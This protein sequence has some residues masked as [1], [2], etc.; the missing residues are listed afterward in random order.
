MVTQRDIQEDINFVNEFRN[1]AARAMGLRMQIVQNR[2]RAIH[3]LK[4][5]LQKCVNM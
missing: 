4:Q 5:D 1:N 3:L 2:I